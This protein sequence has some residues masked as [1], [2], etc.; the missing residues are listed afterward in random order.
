MVN[1]GCQTH[2]AALAVATTPRRQPLNL[3]AT[4]TWLWVLIAPA[5]GSFFA[6]LAARLP[7]GLDVVARASRCDSC[8]HR[9][10]V[11]DLVPVVSF[12]VL[13]GR[14]RHCGAPIPGALL[15]VEI[16][17]AG[18][19]IWMG[20]LAPNLVMQILG[21]L[22]L[23]TLT[24]L[25]LTDMRLFRL[26]NLLVGMSAILGGAYAILTPNSDIAT[27]IWGA[28]IGAGS[29]AALRWGY[30]RVR[31]R[32]GLG[33]GDVKLMGAIGLTLGPWVLPHVLLGASVSALAWALVTGRTAR[34]NRQRPLPFGA[35]LCLAAG[36][37]FIYFGVPANFQSPH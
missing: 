3:G 7:R 18:Y 31:H 13:R 32:Q 30:Q 34:G 12:V 10:G 8:D 22:F 21:T 33:M 26:P 2:F 5:F 36:A 15:Y 11:R 37:G 23:L 19:A 27:Q 24:A 9:L 28:A 25:F 17:A 29:F 35:F 16:L 6:V 4:E 14:C 20:I 1:T